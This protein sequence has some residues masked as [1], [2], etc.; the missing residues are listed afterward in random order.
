MDRFSRI[1]R[2][3][4]NN[5]FNEL[6]CKKITIIGLGAVGSYVVEALARAGLSNIRVVDFDVIKISNIN[7]QLFALESTLGKYK[8][9]AAV[10]RIRQINPDC[11]VEGYK[12]FAHK[13]T[14]EEILD[15]NPDIVID[16]I[17]SV[18]PKTALLYEL[19]F[20]NIKTISSMGAALRTDPGKI[21]CT[22]LFD[23][24][25]CRL[26]KIIRKKLK[27]LGV[28]RGITCIYSE[29]ITEVFNNVYEDISE[30]EFFRGR[31]RSV[32]GSLSTITGIFGLWI[33]NEAILRLLKE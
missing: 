7:R 13:D 3:I 16:A 26:A 5:N 11:N 2:L 33:A 22:D 6:Q 30:T 23:S 17:D 18:A 14:L 15:N 20:R 29:E 8:V 32:M 9:D 21:R 12:I 24:K 19:Y 4:G 27:R 10:E 31:K 25:K 28:G 1:R